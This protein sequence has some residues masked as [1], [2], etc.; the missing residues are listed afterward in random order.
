MKLKVG[1]VLVIELMVNVGICKVLF[2]V[3]GWIV[4]IQDG[5]LFVYFEYL[6]V[7]IDF[8]L[9]ILG[10]FQGFEL[11]VVVFQLC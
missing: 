11:K 8:G 3:D 4:R 5:L 1:M 9:Q 2:D 6:V 10:C 7:I